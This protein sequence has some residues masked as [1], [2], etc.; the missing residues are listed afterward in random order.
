[1][2]GW[3][4]DPELNNYITFEEH[5]KKLKEKGK[6]TVGELAEALVKVLSEKIKLTVDLRTGEI[7]IERVEK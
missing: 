2:S 3:I 6:E 7:K 1:M 4:F 5:Q